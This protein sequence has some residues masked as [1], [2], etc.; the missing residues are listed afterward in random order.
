[1]ASNSRLT[2]EMAHNDTELGLQ[3]LRNKYL[4]PKCKTNYTPLNRKIYL[5]FRTQGTFRYLEI[6]L[7]TD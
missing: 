5:R 2:H 7:N 1:M 4:N 6:G 3:S